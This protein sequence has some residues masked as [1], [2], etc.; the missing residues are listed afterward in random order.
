MIRG[1]EKHSNRTHRRSVKFRVK[2]YLARLEA[3]EMTNR[4][5]AGLLEIS[6]EHLSRTLAE[7]GLVKVA[8]VDHKAKSAATKARK[9]HIRELAKTLSAEDLA[10]ECKI[11]LRTAYRYKK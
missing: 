2:A 3:R 5:V 10:K 8:P 11:S 1:M 9:D 6:E 7:I 4:E